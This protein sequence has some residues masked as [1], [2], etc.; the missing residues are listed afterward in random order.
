MGVVPCGCQPHDGSVRPSIA[1]T[2]RNVQIAV[3]VLLAPNGAKSEAATSA[4]E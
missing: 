3:T 2:K 1:L 4:D